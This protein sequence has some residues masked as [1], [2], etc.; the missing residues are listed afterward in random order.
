MANTSKNTIFPTINK[1]HIKDTF[2]L[3][4]QLVRNAAKYQS[5][6]INLA[7]TINELSV[8]YDAFMSYPPMRAIIESSGQ[9]TEIHNSLKIYRILYES[10]KKMS[11][12]LNR[13][14]ALPL[15]DDFKSMQVKFSDKKIEKTLKMEE[16]QRTKSML[17]GCTPE[18]SNMQRGLFQQY[19]SAIKFV[20]RKTKKL[21]NYEIHVFQRMVQGIVSYEDQN[22]YNSFILNQSMS[23]DQMEEPTP[24]L[25][26]QSYNNKKSIL[27][28][29]QID[30]GVLEE[31]ILKGLNHDKNPLTNSF[32]K[33]E[34][35][36]SEKNGD[37]KYFPYSNHSPV[38]NNNNI[39]R[40]SVFGKDIL[41]NELELM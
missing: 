29:S 30:N 41:D 37:G 4:N 17:P 40:D 1:N 3:Y 16:K 5:A 19:I 26:Y 13:D 28:V 24:R 38:S 32:I 14:F 39:L 15:N 34:V 9:Q 20:S 18:P 22:V 35:K 27:D 25:N 11:E 8:S 6:M 10:F 12:F 7:T 23:Q 2:G 33:E 21:Q 36:K 31:S